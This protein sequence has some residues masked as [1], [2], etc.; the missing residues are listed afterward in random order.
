MGTE[1]D[2]ELICGR[3]GDVNYNSSDESEREDGGSCP[4][5]LSPG[6]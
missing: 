1:W 5:E 2:R 6:Y 4:W 3:D